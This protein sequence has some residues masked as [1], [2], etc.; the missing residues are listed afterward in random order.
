M[1]RYFINDVL[2]LCVVLSSLYPTLTHDTKTPKYKG[3]YSIDYR[4][5]GSHARGVYPTP[6]T[7]RMGTARVKE[8]E[9]VETL[10]HLVLVSIFFIPL[11]PS[12]N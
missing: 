6:Y 9:E 8:E 11:E 5:R 10:L 2:V 3:P 12:G 7:S 1:T 4:E